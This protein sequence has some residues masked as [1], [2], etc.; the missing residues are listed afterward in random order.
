[1]RNWG[2]CIQS[3]FRIGHVLTKKLKILKNFLEYGEK[4]NQNGQ[5]MLQL[6]WGSIKKIDNFGISHW[7][8]ELIKLLKELLIFISI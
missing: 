5:W 2:F 3:T 8:D 1:M 4:N 7:N 6:N